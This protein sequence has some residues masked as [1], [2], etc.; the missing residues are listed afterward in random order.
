MFEIKLDILGKI[1]YYRGIE[2]YWKL[3]KMVKHSKHIFI[4][5]EK[6]FLKILNS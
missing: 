4:L 5:I 3:K 2:Y 6:L 1:I